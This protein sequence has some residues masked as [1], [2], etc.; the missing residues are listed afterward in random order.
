MKKIYL[1][2]LTVLAVSCQS[3][4]KVMV[5]LT[6]NGDC[7]FEND[8]VAY[9]IYGAQSDIIS[10]GADIWVKAQGKLILDKWYK[11]SETDPQYFYRNQTGIKEYPGRDCYNVQ[12]FSLY[13]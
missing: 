1:I 11:L 6:D 2:I 7:I 4:Q 12:F 8:R 10:P 5:R 9:R 3:N 13:L